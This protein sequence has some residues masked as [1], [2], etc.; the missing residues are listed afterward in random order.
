M[1]ATTPVEYRHDRRT[2]QT[3]RRK[4][5]V[6]SEAFAVQADEKQGEQREAQRDR[7]M[8]DLQAQAP[9]PLHQGRVGRDH[10]A[11]YLI[12]SLPDQLQPLGLDPVTHGGQLQDPVRQ[13]WRSVMR[14]F[15]EGTQQCGR[16]AYGDEAEVDERHDDDRADDRRKA[17][18]S[19][20]I[21]SRSRKPLQPMVIK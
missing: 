6:V 8:Q 11:A 10:G 1:A 19:P 20:Q 18:G 13:W 4:G 9:G 14:G 12:V 7:A 17:H 15:R 2:E 21:T 5:H 3:L 16:F